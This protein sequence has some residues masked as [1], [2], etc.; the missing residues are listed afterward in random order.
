VSAYKNTPGFKKRKDGAREVH[1]E[2]LRS[3]RSGK[4]EPG[5]N[6]AMHEL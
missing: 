2:I 1:V 5:I 4:M 3:L 6:T